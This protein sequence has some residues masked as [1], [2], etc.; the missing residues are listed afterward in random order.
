[1]C[2]DISV[3]IF[4]FNLNKLIIPK[5]IIVEFSVNLSQHSCSELQK[6]LPVFWDLVEMSEFLPVIKKKKN[7]K[8]V[9][10][11]LFVLTF[12]QPALDSLQMLSQL[13]VKIAL[14]LLIRRVNKIA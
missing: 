2:L 1:M 9:A 11:Y 5:D 8:I 14:T 6:N 12:P 3:Y 10:I 7:F 4:V 13:I